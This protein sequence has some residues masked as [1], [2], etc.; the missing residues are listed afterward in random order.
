MIEL[1]FD[2]A[3]TYALS[4]AGV[5]RGSDGAHIPADESNA[6]WR[7]FLEWQ[8]SGK[9][10]SPYQ[11]PPFDPGVVFDECKRR[12]FAVAS[13]NAQLNRAAARAAG[14]MST[15]DETAFASG[16]QWIADMR[17]SC[18]ALIAAQDATFAD[19]AHWPACPAE[20]AALAARF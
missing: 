6:D 3:E 9:T 19:E 14:V 20:T 13:T 7:A 12:I 17:T 18:A 4:E 5:V 1:T 16:L 11:P 15:E 2:P 10:A 8:A